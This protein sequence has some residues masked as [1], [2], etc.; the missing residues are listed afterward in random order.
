MEDKNNVD[1]EYNISDDILDSTARFMFNVFNS[2]SGNYCKGFDE[3]L[4]SGGGGN[5]M[6]VNCWT[7][8]SGYFIKVRISGKKE[9][10]LFEFGYDDINSA[11]HEFKHNNA[12]G[13]E[14]RIKNGKHLHLD[15]NPG[16]VKVLQLIREKCRSYDTNLEYEEIIKDLKNYLKNIQ[17]LDWIT[18]E[19]DDKRTYG[20]PQHTKSEKNMMPHDERDALLNDTWKDL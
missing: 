14:K 4:M 16:N 1:S 15:H 20:D 12:K 19:Q 2:K 17:T 18:V 9:K 8:P 10:K 5:S 11:P 7:K 6:F 13:A 3:L